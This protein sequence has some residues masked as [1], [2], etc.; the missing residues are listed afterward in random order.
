MDVTN[1][2]NSIFD[3]ILNG[4]GFCFETLDSITFRGV[5]LL[6]FMIT[7]FVLGVALPLV[8]ATVTSRP[9]GGDFS[10]RNTGT[11]HDRYV[12]TDYADR[13]RNEWD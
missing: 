10:R 5:S 11:E 13:H 12:K 4:I 7:L 6:D 9:S 8:I 2:F 3:L 1:A